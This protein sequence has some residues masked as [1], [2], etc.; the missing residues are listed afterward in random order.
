MPNISKQKEWWRNIFNE[1]YLKTYIDT[2]TP[3]RTIKEANFLLKNLNLKKKDKILDLACG[4]GRHSIELARRGYNVTGFDFSKYFL[5]T[6]RKEARKQNMKIVF[7]RGDMRKLPFINKFDVIINMFT[8]FGYFEKDKDNEI[9]LQKIAHALK[10]KGRLLIELNN[11]TRTLSGMLQKGEIDKK[12][13]LLTTRDKY[14]LSNGL[15]ITTKGEFNLETMHWS[16]RRTWR[17]KR[18]I[19]S[20]KFNV[21]MFHLP[22]LKHLFEE[23]RLRIKKI[24]GDF[25]GSALKFDSRR[26]IILA[27]KI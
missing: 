22:E 16:L 2:V 12:T 19:R 21:R 23:N 14:K 8:S 18:R 9:V 3:E 11:I 15:T 27:E 6:A 13:G 7:V 10:P 20:Y 17:E 24:W 1:K 25:D 5:Q 26:L 4:Y